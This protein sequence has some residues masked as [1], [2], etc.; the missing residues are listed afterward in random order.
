MASFPASRDHKIEGFHRYSVKPA[1]EQ[2][3]GIEVNPNLARRSTNQPG[4]RWHHWSVSTQ[5]K[6]EEFE[7][8]LCTGGPGVRLIGTLNQ[9]GEPSSAEGAI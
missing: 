3:K 6:P 5:V 9:P 8:L 1:A 7:I 4:R 2:Y